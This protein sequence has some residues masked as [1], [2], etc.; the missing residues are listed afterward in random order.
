MFFFFFAS[1][2][3]VV[4]GKRYMRASVKGISECADLFW[5]S[6]EWFG[7]ATGACR[8]FITVGGCWGYLHENPAV[9]LIGR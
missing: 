3:F 7:K 1:V 8:R 4:L 2:V 6:H 9:A 5:M